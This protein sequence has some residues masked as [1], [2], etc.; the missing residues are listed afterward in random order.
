MSSTISSPRDDTWM[1][2]AL[3]E[4]LDGL[5]MGHR[6]QPSLLAPLRVAGGRRQIPSTEQL[7]VP[8]DH[9]F[10]PIRVDT[11]PPRP[12][13]TEADRMPADQGKQQLTDQGPPPLVPL[14]TTRAPSTQ[15]TQEGSHR[16]G[17][18]HKQPAHRRAHKPAGFQAV[19]APDPDGEVEAALRE[20]L[21]DLPPDV[22]EEMAHGAEGLD[23]E[24]LFWE[25]PDEDGVELPMRPASDQSDQSADEPRSPSPQFQ[26]DYEV[27]SS[28]EGEADEIIQI[29]DSDN[30]E[31]NFRPPGTPPPAYEYIFGPGPYATSCPIT[32]CAASSPS[33]SPPTTSRGYHAAVA[34]R[35]V[36]GP[37]TSQHIDLATDEDS[38]DERPA[39]AVPSRPPLPTPGEYA[40][41]VARRRAEDLSDELGSSSA[42]P[43]RPINPEPRSARDRP[44]TPAPARRGRRRSAPWADS[45]SE[46]SSEEELPR[47]R[48]GHTLNSSRITRPPGTPPPVYEDI[49]GPGPYA[50]S[51]PITTCAA[52]SPSQSPPT[53]SCGYHAA[54]APRQVDG[55]STSQHIDLATD[56]D[57][58]DERPAVAVPSRPPLP[59]PGEYAAAVARRRAE[60]LSDE[61]GSSSAGPVRP[62]NPEPRSARDRPPTPAPARRDRRRSAPWADSPN[63]SSS[64]EELP[65]DRQ[66][67]TR[68]LPVPDG[69]STPNG[70]L[71]AGL[72]SRIQQRLL[73]ARRR[74]RRYLEEEQGQRFRVQLNRD[75]HVRV[76]LHPTRK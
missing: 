72:I 23:L 57:S 24:D 40:A 49:F 6:P 55:P 31:P 33:Q 44:P 41:A 45:P 38:A 13:P 51:C 2:L 7:D 29:S 47:D 66:G 67:H 74:A 75:D 46:S 58:A 63:E 61:L 76:F 43:V 36:D 16:H 59:T 21:G 11:T 15:A 9:R 4:L 34:P 62:I 14:R 18:H 71:P 65:R 64:E 68:W 60:D 5:Q 12:R 54:V 3:E 27:I 10:G 70:T 25:S 50:T 1:G 42:G 69:W 19:A 8:P 48:Q 17:R 20:C 73:I 39:V 28:D 35:Q 52:S 56:E 37:S 53:T 22:L 26:P 30:A 32:T